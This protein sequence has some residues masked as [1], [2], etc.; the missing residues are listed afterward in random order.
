MDRLQHAVSDVSKSDRAF[1]RERSARD[2]ARY[3]CPPLPNLKPAFARRSSFRNGVRFMS[4]SA[5][6]PAKSDLSIRTM[7]PD[8]ISIAVDWAAAEG[9]N[10]GLAD[11]ACFAAA[12]PEGFFIGELEGAP[13]ATISCV[14][15][16]TSFA[17]LGFYIVRAD[18][19]GRGY[20]L[21]IWNAAIAH[22]GPRVIG[23]DGVV[24]QQENY[25]KS[26]FQLAYA[27]VRY[28]GT[29]AAPATP[30]ADVI[31]LS[32]VPMAAVEADD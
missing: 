17:F 24:A 11:D 5:R 27:N 28:G 15:Y 13:A 14:N 22:A 2:F 4:P 9:W 8:E 16:G 3:S 1:N 30:R 19:R 18:L 7:R 25:R 29:V 6:S 23:L 21:R 12:D 31:A 26:G 20:G 10:P 32:D